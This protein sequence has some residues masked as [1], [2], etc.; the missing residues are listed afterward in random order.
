MIVQY[1]IIYFFVDKNLI[2]LF[3]T[4]LSLINSDN[5]RFTV[6]YNS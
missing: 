4:H 2:H 1:N 3:G 5:L 6:V